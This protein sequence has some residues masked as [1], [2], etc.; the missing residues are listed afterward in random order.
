MGI[1]AA[2][3]LLLALINQSGTISAA[4]TK[5]RSEGRTSLTGEE[6]GSILTRDDVARAAQIAALEHAKSEG[7]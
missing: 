7:R 1:D 5:A 6:W 4:I 2:I 3:A